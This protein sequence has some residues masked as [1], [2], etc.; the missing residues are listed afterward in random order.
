MTGIPAF[1]HLPHPP[2]PPSPSLSHFIPFGGRASTGRRELHFGMWQHVPCLPLS[3]S[4]SS[5]HATIYV[6]PCI[7]LCPNFLCAQHVF[8]MCL[9]CLLCASPLLLCWH[10]LP[11]AAC[12]H[13][14]ACWQLRQAVPIP[15]ML[16]VPSC[17]SEKEQ[18]GS[19]SSMAVACG[20]G[21]LPPSKTSG[22]VLVA[23][24]HS[25]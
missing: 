15:N 11:A 24:A 7:P 18:L 6:C 13:G 9:P 16:P 3:L 8:L 19:S 23:A 17:P 5:V 25:S 22:L 10:A 2:T 20:S 4:F 1:P 12:K 14:L 21:F